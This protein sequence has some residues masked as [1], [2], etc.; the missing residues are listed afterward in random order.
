[1]CLD[2]EKIANLSK[3]VLLNACSAYSF[4]AADYEKRRLK[5][6][7]S[8]AARSRNVNSFK[9]ESSKITL[10]GAFFGLYLASF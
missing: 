4:R 5:L 9:S 10:L 8:K 3:K 6:V 2:L 7:S 1:M